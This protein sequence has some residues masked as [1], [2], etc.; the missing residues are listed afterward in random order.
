M[1][2]VFNPSLL[3]SLGP[4][5][6]KA[7]EVSKKLL[8]RLPGHFRNLIACYDIDSLDKLSQEIQEILDT[9]LLAAKHLNKLVD[10]GYKIRSENISAVKVNLYLFMDAYDAPI[11]PLE[12]VEKL[13]ALKYG[14]IDRDQHSGASLFII[15]IL[16]K[17]WLQEESASIEAVDDLRQALAYMAREDV[18]LSMDSK[19]YVLQSISSD[20]TRIPRQELEHISATLVYLSVL[21]SKAPPLSQFNRRLLM[22]ERNYKV[23]T[24]GI[25]S[26]TVFRERLLD[27]FSRYLTIDII[28]YCCEQEPNEDYSGCRIFEMTDNEYW[29]EALKQGSGLNDIA[30]VPEFEKSWDLYHGLGDEPSRT[31]EE[32]MRW[33]EELEKQHLIAVRQRIERSA[34]GLREE[35]CRSLNSDLKEIVTFTGLKGGIKYLNRLESELVKERAKCKPAPVGGSSLVKRTAANHNRIEDIHQCINN[36]PEP[37]G[38]AVKVIILAVFI[39]YSIINLAFPFLEQSFRILASLV[40]L[41]AYMIGAYVYYLHNYRRIEDLVEEYKE[42]VESK[43]SSTINACLDNKIT[44]SYSNIINYAAVMKEKLVKCIR[45]YEKLIENAEPGKS[46]GEEALGNL[47]TDLLDF[48][49]RR[50]FYKER[51]PKAVE[52]YPCFLG[53]LGGYEELIKQP[54]LNKLL[55]V[56]RGLSEKY[57][58]LDFFEYMRFKFGDNVDEELLKWIE[59]G[60]AKSRY[61]LQYASRKDLEEHS[62]FMASAEVFK[63][64]KERISERL[65]DFQ[66]SLIEDKDVFTDCVSIVKLCLGIDLDDIAS[67]RRLARRE[68]SA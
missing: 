6:Q 26:V 23:G 20:G 39:Y 59:R 45:D 44:E 40:Y 27:E 46:E 14:N 58:E 51:A 55:E 61:L 1:N 12:I 8:G 50:N 33:K 38:Y 25:T 18:M 53:K 48:N 2:E 37:A 15:S 43:L 22:H 63:Q 34:E 28:R 29:K 56:A 13:A 35:M 36:S 7:L 42:E 32:L 49:D 67:I 60:T 47:V 24:I 21:P 41:A 65:G 11:P 57:I 4:S 52:L 68:E 54:G 19:M 66:V 17:E 31:Q 30:E 16:E 62:F 3:I 9:K 64:S 10:L 5:A